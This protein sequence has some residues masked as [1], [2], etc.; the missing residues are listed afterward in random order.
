M[1]VVVGITDNDAIFYTNMLMCL[2]YIVM[3]SVASALF[4]RRSDAIMRSARRLALAA[5]SR[6]GA[7]GGGGI[8]AFALGESGVDGEGSSRRRGRHPRRDRSPDAW[9]AQKQRAAEHRQRL[10]SGRQTPSEG[11]VCGGDESPR[12]RGIGIDSPCRPSVNASF[13]GAV[14]EEEGGGEKGYTKTQ[15]QTRTSMTPSPAR[16][17]GASVREH[18]LRG[19]GMGLRTT[20]SEG[21]LC[22]AGSPRTL[23]PHP[24]QRFPS[25]TSTTT[26][27]LVI[28]DGTIV[29][30]TRSSSS[31]AQ[32]QPHARVSNF[33]PRPVVQ[34][35]PAP[36]TPRS[37]YAFR[38]ASSFGSLQQRQ[39]NAHV[40]YASPLDSPSRR[41][42][43]HGTPRPTLSSSSYSPRVVSVTAANGEEDNT[44]K[45]E[46]ANQHTTNV[47][48]EA[49]VAVINVGD[50][51]AGARR[52]RRNPR[53]LLW[54]SSGVPHYTT[55]DAD[56]PLRCG[57]FISAL[58]VWLMGASNVDG[59]RKEKINNE[60]TNGEVGQR[61]DH[62]VDA[63]H[64]SQRPR[65]PTCIAGEGSGAVRGEEAEEGI[66]QPETDEAEVRRRLLVARKE[67]TAPPLEK[68]APLGEGASVRRKKERAAAPLHGF[69]SDLPPS[70]RVRPV[71]FIT[72]NVGRFL[73]FLVVFLTFR[74]V[75]HISLLFFRERDLGDTGVS[76]YVISSEAVQDRAEALIV[77][78]L[79]LF[80]MLPQVLLW[81]FA[82]MLER[83]N[84]AKRAAGVLTKLLAVAV[85]IAFW[86]LATLYAV[87]V[88]DPHNVESRFVSISGG[89]VVAYIIAFFYFPYEFAKFGAVVDD[90]VRRVRRC[91][92]VFAVCSAVRVALLVDPMQD[93]IESAIAPEWFLTFYM[94]LELIPTL[95]LMH[96]LHKRTAREG[97]GANP[98]AAAA[99]SSAS[100]ALIPPQ[101]TPNTNN[102]RPLEADAAASHDNAR[103]DDSADAHAVNSARRTAKVGV[104][105]VGAPPLAPPRDVESSI[106]ELADVVGGCAS[107][108]P[109]PSVLRRSFADF[110][111]ADGPPMRRHSPRRGGLVPLRRSEGARGSDGN[112]SLN[113]S[114][115]SAP[116]SHPNGGGWP[117]LFS[118]GSATHKPNRSTDGT[119]QQNIHLPAQLRPEQVSTD[120]GELE[121]E[122]GAKE[123]DAALLVSPPTT[124]LFSPAAERQQEFQQEQQQRPLALQNSA[125]HAAGVGMGGGVFGRA[126]ESA[127]SHPLV[128]D[129]SPLLFEGLSTRGLLASARAISGHVG[130]LTSASSS[131]GDLS[132]MTSDDC[133]DDR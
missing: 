28:I 67:E 84:P 29:N 104:V 86:L 66:G 9:P 99:A 64:R 96:F 87:D 40:R 109:P 120:G 55:A 116:S 56:E 107:R 82:S 94:P 51:A 43:L 114:M 14:A 126:V 81:T 97:V 115:A 93:I 89:Y 100:A 21:G 48:K 4:I 59:T 8:A 5:R 80:Y 105:V 38:R 36:T 12:R 85:T 10:R 52:A 49:S 106:G 25:P 65:L 33:A 15:Y 83:A 102:T 128:G 2:L 1:R 7:V 39:S 130:G 121:G 92:A 22:A 127:S 132:D 32:G 18:A 6:S 125:D 68:K 62:D 70:F 98:A 24:Q 103:S 129:V 110:A 58:T 47:T 61:T 35:P 57:R 71:D 19:A 69:P 13:G 111:S 63:A 78:P 79:Y 42:S 124:S 46:V 60:N 133:G 50:E 123:S 54:C 101:R 30:S 113:F 77:F 16:S 3:A 53:V 119:V 41:G 131:Y 76:F 37:G 44:E 90:V 11:A 108:L 26:A 117:R 73:L 17:R 72:D 45:E 34:R 88:I 20:S 112:L 118:G 23:L 31:Q 74:V 75:S 95:F 91:C 27:P 122:E